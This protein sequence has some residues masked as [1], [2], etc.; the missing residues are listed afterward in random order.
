MQCKPGGALILKPMTE[1][2]EHP[3]N[4]GVARKFSYRFYALS[5]RR[6]ATINQP[7]QS[8]RRKQ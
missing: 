7:N 2:D 5:R 1:S 8:Q 6:A 3:L 4:R